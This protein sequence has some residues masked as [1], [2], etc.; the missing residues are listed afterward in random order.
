MTKAE[1]EKR[2]AQIEKEIQLLKVD[3][4]AQSAKYNATN[5][6]SCK[7]K[8]ALIQDELA[9]LAKELVH[10]KEDFD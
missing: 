6:R 8:V 2:I 9:T 1:R 10:L 3:A 7:Y 5:K 4:K